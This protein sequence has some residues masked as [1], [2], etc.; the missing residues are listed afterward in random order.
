MNSEHTFAI[1][2]YKE[3]KYLQN[4]IDSL[5]N[6]TTK[7]NIIL[8]TSTP[9]A[10]LENITKK[11]N[12]AY[13]INPS[14]TGIANDWNFALG[15]AISSIVTL[16]HQDDVYHPQ[17]TEK[18]LKEIALNNDAI[19]IFTSYDEIVH[20]KDKTFVRKNSLNFFIKKI[21]LLLIF[22][23][24][25]SIKK[26]KSWLLATGS[27][28][29]CPTVAYCKN[30]IGQFGFDEK[31]SINVD[32]KAWYDLSQK[33]GSFVWIKKTLVSHRIYSESETSIGLAENRRQ[34]ED[35]Q[36]FEKV[37]PTKIAKIINKVY[38]L[39]YKNNHN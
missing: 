12:I 2:A 14:R 26:N 39:S 19:I 15:S 28:I 37:W 7:S 36:M 16:A 5:N 18:I 17:Y 29:G 38:S 9:S 30:N 20:R 3:S 31:F 25:N 23:F 35:I 21:I 6:Q 4:C 27:P 22:A 33:N 13:H 10:F 11:N 32:W 34:A 24:K 1:L 8:C